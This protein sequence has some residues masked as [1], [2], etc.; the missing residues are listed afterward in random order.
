MCIKA[1][2][3]LLSGDIA[4]ACVKE[5]QAWGFGG[6]ASG[7]SASATS[8]ASGVCGSRSARA[9]A[10][11]FDAHC[12]SGASG[13]S[14]ASGAHDLRSHHGQQGGFERTTTQ[15]HYGPDG[16]ITQ[17]TTHE[18]S[19]RSGGHGSYGGYGGYNS[20]G[21][22]G[23]L[24]EGAYGLSSAAGFGHGCSRSLDFASS[25]GAWSAGAAG[26]FSANMVSIQ[27]VGPLASL[28]AVFKNLLGGAQ[29][30]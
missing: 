28:G 2:A 1:I 4:G 6:A 12:A 11:K 14:R 18:S 27:P 17:S 5:M 20:Y 3:S 9:C 29:A 8:A 22:H 7:A 26:H 21:G 10:S 16:S 24:H 30:A 25:G 23:A 15:T 13:T 19:G